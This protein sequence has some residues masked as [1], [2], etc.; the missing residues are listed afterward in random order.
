MYLK[1]TSTVHRNDLHVHAHV[2]VHVDIVLLYYMVQL[3]GLNT[4]CLHASVM[5]TL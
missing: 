3:S 2:H 5:L 4:S 1:T